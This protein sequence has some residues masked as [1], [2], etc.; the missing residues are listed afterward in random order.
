MAFAEAMDFRERK[1]SAKQI[2][3]GRV[4]KPM[5]VQPP[6]GTRIDE[7]VKHQV[8]Q[9]LLPAGALATGVSLSD[10][11]VG[12]CRAVTGPTTTVR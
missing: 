3:D 10:D 2:L 7:P 5:L 1:I 9:Y 11:T 4:I 8:V 12:A 6:L